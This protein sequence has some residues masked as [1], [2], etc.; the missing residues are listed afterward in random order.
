MMKCKPMQPMGLGIEPITSFLAGGLSTIFRQ[1]CG[2]KALRHLHTMMS[3]QT[4]SVIK[5]YI[6]LD[7]SESFLNPILQSWKLVGP[8]SKYG[9]I[10]ER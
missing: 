8:Q 7:L 6:L 3:S 9:I 4:V 10:M 2:S 5:L 1:Q